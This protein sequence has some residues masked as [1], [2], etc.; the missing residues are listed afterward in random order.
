M[1]D[2]DE[3]FEICK[4]SFAKDPKESG[5]DYW[6]ELASYFASF[7]FEAFGKLEHEDIPLE[8]IKKEIFNQNSEHKLLL[9]MFCGAEQIMIPELAIWK[10]GSHKEDKIILAGFEKT[11]LEK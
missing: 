10:E 2:Y 5:E 3:I 4:L 7:I 8:A 6:D 9:A 1:F 11:L